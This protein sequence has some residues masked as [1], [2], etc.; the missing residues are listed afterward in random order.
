MKKF[1]NISILTK[2]GDNVHIISGLINVKEMNYVLM[3][4]LFH[5]LYLWLYVFNI[6]GIRE[7]LLVNDLNSNWATCLNLFAKIYCSIGPL[8]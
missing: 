5:D 7:Y 2:L 3:W 8:S 1:E 6:V 4:H